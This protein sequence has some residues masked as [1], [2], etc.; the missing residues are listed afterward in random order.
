[1]DKKIVKRFSNR[2]GTVTVVFD[3][4][5]YFVRIEIYS[6][7]RKGIPQTAREY[8]YLDPVI[9]GEYYNACVNELKGRSVIA[10]KTFCAL[11]HKSCNE[12]TCPS[13]IGGAEYWKIFQA[14]CIHR[15]VR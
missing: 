11:C 10:P 2:R 3:G 9:A 1:M 4:V 14:S 6:N 5:S 15:K 13:K 7:L 12:Y 8:M